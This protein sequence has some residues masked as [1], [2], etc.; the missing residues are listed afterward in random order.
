MRS[1]RF[2]GASGRIHNFEAIGM[3]VAGGRTSEIKFNPGHVLN[4]N[5]QEKF[6]DW[7]RLDHEH[8][9]LTLGSFL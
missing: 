1:A 7:A 9:R 5:C 8:C 6:T 2:A 4:L 3:D